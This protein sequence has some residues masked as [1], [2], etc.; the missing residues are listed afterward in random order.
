MNSRPH[1]LSV[2]STRIWD[3]TVLSPHG[4]R[5]DGAAGSSDLSHSPPFEGIP[6]THT[7]DETRFEKGR[8]RVKKKRYVGLG[9]S[10]IQGGVIF[11]CCAEWCH[12][13]P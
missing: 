9:I 8:H 2:M 1:S 11:D 4:N 5:G 6:Y 12:A 13:R 3:W 7:A 10:S